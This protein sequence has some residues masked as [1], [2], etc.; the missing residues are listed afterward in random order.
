MENNVGEIA[1]SF[2]Y[3]WNNYKDNDRKHSC[4]ESYMQEHL[5]K[6]FNN[7]GHNG[8]LKNVSVTLINKTDGKNPKKREG[9][10]NRT[11]KTYSPFGLN[12]QDG[13]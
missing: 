2:R 13:V 3:R 7:M 1:D 12:V 9:Y 5:L 6:H 4:K 8:F 10:W 11:L